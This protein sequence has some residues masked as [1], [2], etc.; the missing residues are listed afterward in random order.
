MRMIEEYFE[1][2]SEDFRSDNTEE[3]MLFRIEAMEQNI[4]QLQEMIEV[5]NLEMK[6]LELF[7]EDQ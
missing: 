5:M 3:R 1:A 2:D 7:I 4:K 6:I